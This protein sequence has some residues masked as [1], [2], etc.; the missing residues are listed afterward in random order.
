MD[1]PFQNPND[2]NPFEQPIQYVPA[3][4]PPVAPQVVIVEH[5]DKN[6]LLEIPGVFC[7]S[8]FCGPCYAFVHLCCM[9]CR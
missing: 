3:Y 4:I 1:S 7:I 2:T 6:L 8:Y 5:T 9:V